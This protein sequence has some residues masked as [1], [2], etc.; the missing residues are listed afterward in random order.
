MSVPAEIRG[1]EEKGSKTPSDEELLR[2]FART[3]S[4]EVFA[5]LV[6]RHIHWVY[7]AALRQTGDHTIAEDATQTV[8]TA[9]ARKSGSFGTQTV[10][11]GWLF[12]A[13]R[14]AVLDALKL[15]TRRRNRE[16]EA[17]KMETVSTAVPAPLNNDAKWDEIAPLLDPGLESLGETDRAAILLRY[18]EQKGWSEIGKTMGVREDA[19][20]LRVTRALEKL[21]GFFSRR[22]VTVS[23]LLMGSLLVEHTVQAAPPALVV[24][25]GRVAVASGGAS[26]GIQSL[27]RRFWW[28]A[29][30]RVGVTTLALLLAIGGLTVVVRAPLSGTGIARTVPI[31][32]LAP[33][34]TELDQAFMAGN[35][36]LFIGRL[37]FRNA[38][39]REMEPSIRQFIVQAAAFQKQVVA[40]FAVYDSIYYITLDDLLAGRPDPSTL[41]VDQDHT[42]SHFAQ[43]RPI[44]LIN[45]GGTWKWDFFVGLSHDQW[46]DRATRLQQKC[47]AMSRLINSMHNGEATN[48]ALVKQAYMAAGR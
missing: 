23:L 11:S 8:F 37:H 30:I 10:V 6:A 25:V 33:A 45:D 48:L 44:L 2:E 4:D 31:A 38:A 1:D 9:L 42:I 24:Q 39:D 19:A 21:R 43:D 35:P 26:D 5:S 32:D 20:R 22:G 47:A 28:R 3:Q 7:S 27:L 13:V 34:L 12:R 29:A 46:Q 41:A 18:Y 36:D 15:A 17:M 14:Y 16:R 40:S